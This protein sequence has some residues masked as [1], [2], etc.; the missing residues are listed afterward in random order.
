[1]GVLQADQFTSRPN[2]IVATPMEIEFGMIMQGLTPPVVLN[3]PQRELKIEKYTELLD[4]EDAALEVQWVV[5]EI[6]RVSWMRLAEIPCSNF[7]N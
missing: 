1:M 6:V 3:D 5:R 7:E 2:N 4:S